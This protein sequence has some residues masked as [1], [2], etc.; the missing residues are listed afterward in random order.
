MSNKLPTIKEI[1]KRLNISVSTVS[2]ALHDHPSIGLR[3]KMRVQELAKEINYEPNQTAIFFQQRKTFSIGVVLPDLSE[4]FF[5]AAI[6]G[7][8]DIAYQNKYTVLLAQSHDDEEKEKLIFNTMKNHRVD[9]VLVSIGKNISNYD[10]YEMMKKYNIPVVFFDRIPKLENIHYVASDLQ[11]GT[12]EAVDFLLKKGHRA[13]GMINGPETLLASQERLQGY[14]NAMKKNR[15]KFDPSLIISSNLTTESTQ[16]AIQELLSSKR[17]PTAIVTFNDYVALD[18]IKYARKANLQINKDLSIVSY[19]NLPIIHYLEFTPLASV[20]QF[21]FRQGQKATEI[22][23]DI[24]AGRND[25]KAETAVH[26][27]VIIESKL[28]VHE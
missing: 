10:H 17:K 6:N 14:I 28:I 24:I 13:I 7:I 23:L 16:S 2:R 21:P 15:L 4:A 26:H 12:R 27:N 20:E 18:A 1:A 11:T 22:L 5:S 9:G 8:E 25:E 19:A 3:T